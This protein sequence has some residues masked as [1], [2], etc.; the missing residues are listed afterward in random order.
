MDLWGVE[1]GRPRGDGRQ[2]FGVVVRDGRQHVAV[3]LA[4]V[5][6]AQP[7]QQRVHLVPAA[8]RPTF[9]RSFEREAGTEMWGEKIL[10]S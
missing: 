3:R 4:V 2:Q 10:G 9:R 5:K 6:E 7:R 8:P 1:Q